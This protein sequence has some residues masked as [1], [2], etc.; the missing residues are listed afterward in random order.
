MMLK[1]SIRNSHPKSWLP[2]EMQRRESKIMRK[3]LW[4]LMQRGYD[5]VSIH[6]AIL[7][8]DTDNNHSRTQV[9]YEFGETLDNVEREVERELQF[10]YWEE[11]MGC[12]VG[13]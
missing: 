6:D 1:A 12:A 10:A 2:L 3:V 4:T 8:L 13:W 7:M 9:D 5:V 11:G